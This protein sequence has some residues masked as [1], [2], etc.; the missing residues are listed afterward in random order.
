MAQY[1]CGYIPDPEGHTRTPFHHVMGLLAPAPAN[2]Y[3]ASLET[4]LPPTMDQNG[5]GSCTGHAYAGA[6]ATYTTASGAPLG[7]VPSPDDIY[8]GERAI[9]RLPDAN[10]KLPPLQDVGAQ[11][12]QGERYINEWGVRPMIALPNRCS[13]VDPNTVNDEPVLGNLR[14]DSVNLLIGAYEIFASGSS[15]GQ[16]IRQA[17]TN[18][19][20]VAVAVPGGS[21]AW[22]RYAG[23]T[24]VIGA[25]GTELD[26][27]VF[28]YK[29]AQQPDGSYLYWI[30]NSWSEFWGING[31][32]IINEA[33]L[34]EFG[35]IIA[36][37]VRK[38]AA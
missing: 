8:K 5:S 28:I 16:Q 18:G 38:K 32:C 17:L 13:D 1:S 9:D 29:Y 12:N 3:Q 37:M 22:Q 25:T 31:S 11:P 2:V 26:H 21:D 7:W 30:R 20:P 27:Y 33:A 24:S 4:S 36:M 34:E 23:G 6:I 35:D 10:G 14:K 19:I 15:L